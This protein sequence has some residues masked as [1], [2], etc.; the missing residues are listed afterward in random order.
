MAFTKLEPKSVNTSATFTFANANVTGNL[1]VSGVT[2]LGDVS[3]LKI[4]G[5]VDGYILST[6]GSGG[7]TWVENLGSGGGVITSGFK[8]ITKDSFT[9]DGSTSQFT[10]SVVPPGIEYIVVNIDGILQQQVSYSLVGDVLTLSETPASGEIIEVTSYLAG[11]ALVAGNTSEIQFNTNDDLDSSPHLTF[12]KTSNTLFASF[13]S[14]DGSKIGNIRAAN[15]Y[16]EV[17][18]SHIAGTVFMNAQPNITS[19]GNLTNLTSNG[20]V[21][22]SNAG[23]VL[24]GSVDNLNI[25]G[26]LSGQVLTTDGAGNV[27]W[28]TVQGGTGGG[29]GGGGATVAGLDTQIQFNYNGEL[30]ATG[31][32]TFDYANGVFATPTA[33][34]GNITATTKV[35]FSGASNVTLGSNANVHISGGSSG[36]L[37]STNGSG[38]LSWISPP[39]T[40][41]A[42]T[43]GQVTN[44]SQPNITSVGT[45]ANLTVTSNIT[46]GNLKT[47]HLL[48]ANG[49]PYIFTTSAAGSNTQVQFNN[50]NLF[51]GSAN[52]TYNN[53]SKTLTVDKIVANGAGLTNLVGA[54]VSGEV[55]TAN[56][57]SNPS[58]TNITQLGT[59]TGLEVSG[60]ATFD[61]NVHINGTLHVAN[62]VNVNESVITVEEPLLYLNA[63]GQSTYNYDIGFYSQFTQSGNYQHTGLVR[64]HSSGVWNL[65]SN[66]AE[67]TAGHVTI[68]ANTVYDSFKAGNIQAAGVFKGDG[69]QISNINAANVVGT[70]ADLSVNDV[71]NVNIGGGLSGQFLTTDG[72]GNLTWVD[73]SQGVGGGSF[74]I[75]GNSN[76]YV[77]YNGNIRYSVSGV[78]NVAVITPQSMTYTGNI[79]S[80]SGSGGNIT[81]ANVISANTIVTG[82]GLGGNIA[83]AN[84]IS[85]NTVIG[86][87]LQGNGI[88]ISNIAGANVSGQVGN[89]LVAGTVYTNAQP[90]ITSL[91]TLVDLAVTGNVVAGRLKGE[92]GNISNVFGG[93]VVGTVSAATTA[94]TVTTGAQPNIT[95]TGTLTG[96]S[97]TGNVSVVGANVSLGTAA[98]LHILGGQAG[99]ALTTDGTGNLGW[100]AISGTSGGTAIS[101]NYYWQGTVQ[102]NTGTQRLYMPSAATLTKFYMN[103]GT[104]GTTDTSISIKKNGTEIRTATLTSGNSSLMTIAGDSLAANDYLTVDITVAG[105][106]A[107]DLYVTFLLTI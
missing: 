63:S 87:Q 95:S 43:A 100:S 26:G 19:V 16:G 27:S 35:N 104:A 41:F 53:T 76:I 88:S 62:L 38:G 2:H 28:Q 40:T 85:A 10:L 61:Q 3:N 44:P 1:T 29:G 106:S 83:G 9:A 89:S 8:S 12:N 78:A 96:L 48:Y 59:L 11:G 17:P 24:L 97:V 15:I 75:N 51:E 5:G 36:Q 22:F 57:V 4:D 7:L 58:Q 81:G 39:D 14:G 6:N 99:Y 52:F 54:N 91:G 90:N 18:S 77:D 98:N 45:L 65:F 37:L 46:T 79:I 69:G 32:L 80:G 47:N 60:D 31:A 84:V 23:N 66:V 105:A 94:G 103:L 101:K 64:D 33:N 67:P 50:N 102:V 49:D 86:M 30:G 71:A 92:G 73:P 70:F 21:N 42:S 107:V 93:N 34:I 56:V 25:G 68:D 55:A 74:L 20:N 72:A 82:T 13:L